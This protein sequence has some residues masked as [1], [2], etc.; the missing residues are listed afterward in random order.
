MRTVD[1]VGEQAELLGMNDHYALVAVS[2]SHWGMVMVIAP[3]EVMS[4]SPGRG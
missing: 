1:I 4:A 2:I 3:F